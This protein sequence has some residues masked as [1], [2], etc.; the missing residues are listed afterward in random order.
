MSK[1]TLSMSEFIDNTDNK[2]NI[3]NKNNK[4][5]KLSIEFYNDMGHLLYGIKEISHDVKLPDYIRDELYKTAK[6]YLDVIYK[7]YYENGKIKFTTVHY[8]VKEGY[9]KK[10][11]YKYY[12]NGIQ[13]HINVD[14]DVN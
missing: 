13:Y 14:Y 9:Q 11:D 3:N 8:K 12:Y 1:Y 7:P 2:N 6:K 10:Y 5:I 4:N